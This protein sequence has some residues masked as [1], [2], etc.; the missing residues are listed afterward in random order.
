MKQYTHAWLAMMAMKR[1]QKANIPDTYSISAES[2]V[3][4]FKNHRDGVVQ[5]AWYPDEIIK[6]MASSHVLKFKPKKNGDKRFKNLPKTYHFY[7]RSK[8]LNKEKYSYTIESGN[9][10]DRCEA[11]AHSII[12]NLKMLDSEER[13]CPISP[14][15][16]HIAILFFMLS[17]YVADAHMPL[18]C[19]VRQFSEGTKLH[20]KIEDYW[21]KKV[22]ECYEIDKDNE[23]FFYDREGFPNLIKSDEIIDW[24]EQ[25]LVARE[26]VP[27][28]GKDNRNTWDFMT[29]ICQHSYLTAYQMIPGK[30]DENLKWD[31]F[32]ILNTNP[33]FDILSKEIL[34][35]SID[36]ITRIWLRVWKRYLDWLK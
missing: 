28:W 33:N 11:I 14:T 21:D 8:E 5:G 35:D 16:N 1:L 31:D 17:H 3:R 20:A 18:H 12:D 10:P 25:E 23:R 9:L 34:I 7:K 32:L 36:S 30:Y 29:A 26:F 6:D 2:L 27:D 19:D 13:G 15:N 4:W 22:K 24:I